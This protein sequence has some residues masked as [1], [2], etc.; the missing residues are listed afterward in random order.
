[1]E[2][3]QATKIDGGV[4]IPRQ[5]IF[6]EYYEV[7]NLLFRIENSL[8][9]FVYIVLKNQLGGKWAEA[10][11]IFD[12]AQGTIT[13]LAKKRIK[14]AQTYGYLGHSIACPIMHLNSG[15]L[16]RL[17]VSDTYWPCFKPYFFGSKAVIRN[18][19][20]EIGSI[21]NSFAHFRPIKVDDVDVLKLNSKQALIGI[22]Q[23]LNRVL[24]QHDTVPT[25]TQY[26]W[27]TNL[28]TL[29][30][31]QCSLAFHQSDDGDWIRISIKYVCPVIEKDLLWSDRNHFGYTV[32]TIRSSAILMKYA[33]ISRNVCFLSE[34]VF[35]PKMYENNDAEFKKELSFIFS[36]SKLEAKHKNLKESLENLLLD[37]AKET[38]L[39]QQDNLA[40]DDIVYSVTASATLEKGGENSWWVWDYERLRTPVA[41]N[42]PP[43]FWGDIGGI[44]WKNLVK[45]FVATSYKYP[46]MPKDV[47]KMRF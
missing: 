2:W 19:L 17:I 47:S 37:I 27:Y 42:N 44:G 14:Q 33:E 45:D 29:G 5:W 31:D 30:T 16:T 40:R 46:W 6:L 13:S 3:E 22:E 7:L 28:K 36:R 32:L 43:E 10:Q 8:R 4:S 41:E 20:D 24:I 21:R 35:Y 25:N 15:E 12:D 1:M 26:Q 34:N 18:K 39:I 9:I 11:V 38:E 23:F